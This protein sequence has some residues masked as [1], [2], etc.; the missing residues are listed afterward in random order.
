MKFFIKN[1]IGLTNE[2]RQQRQLRYGK[3]K[4][5]EFAKASCRTMLMLEN[6]C[7]ATARLDHF[8]LIVFKDLNN[9]ENV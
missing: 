8:C 7:I 4:K 9:L 3:R 5:E 1:W 6:G 2:K